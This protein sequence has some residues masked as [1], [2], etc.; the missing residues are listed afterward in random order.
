MS[1]SAD[2]QYEPIVPG[3]ELPDFSLPF[4][5]GRNAKLSDYRG[6]RLILFTWASW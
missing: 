3:L 2:D 1:P 4:L 6:T 5:D